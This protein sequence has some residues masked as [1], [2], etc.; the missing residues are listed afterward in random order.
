LAGPLA[1]RERLLRPSG[2]DLVLPGRSLRAKFLFGFVVAGLLPLLFLIYL[3]FGVLMPNTVGGPLFPKGGAA[4]F[5]LVALMGFLQLAGFYVI[6]V[7][8]VSRMHSTLDHEV[9]RLEA[10]TTRTESVLEDLRLANFRLR[11]MSHTDELTE[12]GNRRNF[13]MRLREEI[14]RSSRFG[15]T[16][17]LL[18]I[19][20]DSFKNFNDQFGHPKGDAVLRALGALMRSVSR[21]G[22]VPCRVGGEEFSFILPETGKGDAMILAER[23]RRRMESSVMGPDSRSPITVSVGLAAFPEDGKTPDEIVW[24]ADEALYQSKRAGRNRVTLYTRP[25]DTPPTSREAD[26]QRSA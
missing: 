7:D 12:V 25:P 18:T 16:F 13:D 21:E 2:G 19:D 17:S 15:H 26:P 11:E 5:V 8:V 22:D 14:S 3:G 24:A 1:K 20:I 4:F 6:Y 23:F 9:A 10:S